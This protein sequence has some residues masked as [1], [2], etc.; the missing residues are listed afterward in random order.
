MQKAAS[1][2]YPQRDVHLVR[3]HRYFESATTAEC[4]PK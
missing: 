2:E 3:A 1:L 4:V